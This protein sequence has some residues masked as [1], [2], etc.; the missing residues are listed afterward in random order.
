VSEP[1]AAARYM[2]V[3]RLRKPHGLKGEFAVF[4]LTAEPETVFAEGRTLVR[5]GLD[6][7]VLGEPVKIE[8]SRP[9]HREWLIKFTGTDDRDAL[10]SWRGQFIG[11]EAGLLKPPAEGEVYLHELEGFAVK[12]EAGV[13]LGLVTSLYELASGLTL[14]V[15]GPKREFLLPFKKDFVIATDRATRTL[16]VRIPEGLLD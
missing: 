1:G 6:G 11:A 2:A 14:E 7:S 3:G 10:E 9:F 12:D 8:R 16:V 13:A 5:M 4:P 15:Q